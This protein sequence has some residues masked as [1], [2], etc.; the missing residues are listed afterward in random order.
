VVLHWIHVVVRTVGVAVILFLLV[1]SIAFYFSDEY[2]LLCD[3]FKRIDRE[4]RGQPY[5]CYVSDG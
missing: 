4:R 5:H 1:I 2:D 3:T